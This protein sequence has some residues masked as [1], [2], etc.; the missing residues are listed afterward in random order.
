VVDIVLEY[1]T[2][3]GNL[4]KSTRITGNRMNLWMAWLWLLP[5]C[6]SLVGFS[7]GL[8]SGDYGLIGKSM[9]VFAGTLS[10]SRVGTLRT[11]PI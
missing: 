10:I 8:F 3:L 11:S 1:P 5:V 7:V 4:P 2:N 6:V 9:L